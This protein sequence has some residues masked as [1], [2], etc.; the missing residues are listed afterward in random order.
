M[1]FKSSNYLFFLNIAKIY[2]FSL[3]TSHSQLVYFQGL[4]TTFSLHFPQLDYKLSPAYF[5]KF[6]RLFIRFVRILLF[7]H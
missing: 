4:K 6:M 7:L 3:L 2:N 1:N 5:I